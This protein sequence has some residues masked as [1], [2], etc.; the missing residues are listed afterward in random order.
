MSFHRTPNLLISLAFFERKRSAGPLFRVGTA[1][2]LGWQPM[3]ALVP[4]HKSEILPLRHGM[5]SVSGT[6]LERSGEEGDALGVVLDDR[7][8]LSVVLVSTPSEQPLTRPIARDALE[9]CRPLLQRHAAIYEVVAALRSFGACEAREQ[10]G[11]IV[12]RFSQVEARVELLNAGLSPVCCVMPS[13]DTVL[14]A[15]L[16]PAIGQR[17][18]S[19]HPYELSPLHWGSSW[20]VMSDRLTEDVSA[21]YVSRFARAKLSPTTLDE[22]E[23]PN[24]VLLHELPLEFGSASLIA[25]HAHTRRRF[26]SGIQ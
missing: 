2:A 18:G 8:D 21:D 17:F 15:A 11:V 4:S 23:D 14:H 5:L 7:G 3:A 24:Q 9:L 13:G 20:F 12:L 22:V 6:V 19:V 16:S 1:L 10:V 26:Q 25:V